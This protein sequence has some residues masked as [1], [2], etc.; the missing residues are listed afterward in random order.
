MTS[1][2]T[3]NPGTHRRAPRP[4]AMLGLGIGLIVVL[5]VIVVVMSVRALG[6]DKDVVRPDAS[7]LTVGTC[8]EGLAQPTWVPPAVTVAT[9]ECPQGIS[10]R[11][12][13]LSATDQLGT[14]VIYSLDGVAN[15]E[16]L[17]GTPAGGWSRADAEA[18]AIHPAT[19]IVFVVY[20]GATE[21]S[22]KLRG[23]NL[24]ISDQELDNGRT[25]RLT[26]VDNNGYGPVRLE[27]TDDDGSYVLLSVIGR[28]ADGR[29]GPTVDELVRMAGSVNPEP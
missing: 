23:Q 14:W 15:A 25:A 16:S 9:V 28:T 20:P 7:V 13:F 29:S 19:T 5:L 11:I 1:V 3:H 27:W 4:E 17:P 6:D 22:E 21:T 18:G 2:V 8:A 10:G 12:G 24:V 26:R